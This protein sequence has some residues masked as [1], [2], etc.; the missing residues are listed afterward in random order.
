MREPDTCIC[1]LGWK[2]VN[3]TE[4]VPY[5]GCNINGTVKEGACVKPWECNCVPVGFN[6]LLSCF[7]Y[8]NQ[9]QEVF[10]HALAGPLVI[11]PPLKLFHPLKVQKSLIN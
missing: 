6:S 4:C 9:G 7:K 5:P 1:K 10:C 3:C 11:Y 2:G 8:F